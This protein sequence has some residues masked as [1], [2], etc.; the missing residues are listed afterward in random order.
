MISPMTWK[1]GKRWVY[2]ITNDEGR[3]D[4]LKFAARLHRRYGI[5]RHVELL[6][7]KAAK[8]AE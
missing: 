3:A 7:S 2:S 8:P 5:L 4:L 1:N 6:P